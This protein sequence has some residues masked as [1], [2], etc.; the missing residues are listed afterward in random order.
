MGLTLSK[1]APL[2]IFPDGMACLLLGLL[3]ILTIRQ[4]RRATIFVSTAAFVLLLSAS[5]PWVGLRLVHILEARSI[6]PG[7]VPAADAIVVLA[8]DVSQASPPQPVVWVSA[9]TANRL[10]YAA[11]LYRDGKSR[12]VIVSGGQVPWRKTLPPL[13]AG[14]AE[15]IETMGVPPS[16]ILQESDS[17]NTYESAVRVK[18]ILEAHKLHSILL[19]TSAIHMPR[20]LTLFRQQGTDAFPAPGDFV[21]GLKL[22]N[23]R[24][25]QDSIITMMPSA[26]G[27]QLSTMALREF[28]GAAAN[29]IAG[30]L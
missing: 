26:E 3:V 8:A 4:N 21:S 19:V 16:A 12:I 2:L 18:A 10:L 29:H 27:L 28:L 9:A 14:L 13:S 15:V 22:T 17:A 5:S 11:K 25:L 7:P 1:F 24:S 30:K 20:A 6:P 23:D